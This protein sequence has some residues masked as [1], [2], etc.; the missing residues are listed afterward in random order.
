MIYLYKYLCKHRD[1]RYI[2][3]SSYVSAGMRRYIDVVFLL[4]INE[5]ER[6]EQIIRDQWCDRYDRK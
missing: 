5:G 2:H 3:I 1:D 6:Y 4:D